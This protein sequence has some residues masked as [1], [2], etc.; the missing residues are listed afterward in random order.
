MGLR[1]LL[2]RIR[3]AAREGRYQITQHA[4]EAMS[5]RG[6]VPADVHLALV[7]ATRCWV[8]ESGRTKSVGPDASGDELFIIMEFAGVLLI[9]TLFRD[10]EDEDS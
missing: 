2:R 9:V 8:Q 10:E 3:K 5:E 1:T 7:G 6:V 4:Q